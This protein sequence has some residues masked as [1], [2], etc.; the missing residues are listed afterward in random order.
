[1]HAPANHAELNQLAHETQSADVQEVGARVAP[2]L[3]WRLLQRRIEPVT[4][5][6]TSAYQIA[7]LEAQCVRLQAYSVRLE[8]V[9]RAEGYAPAFFERIRGSHLHPGDIS[10]AEPAP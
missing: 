1:M 10:P 2:S 5:L 6:N 3:G 4:P 7:E 9:L 8:G